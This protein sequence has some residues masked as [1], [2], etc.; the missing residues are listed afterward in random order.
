MM[1][2]RNLG[3]L[4]IQIFNCSYG[5]QNHSAIFR[6]DRSSRCR[7]MAVRFSIFTRAE[8]ALRE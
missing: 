6:A 5:S 3:F 1:A 2:V 4:D 7:D 8:L